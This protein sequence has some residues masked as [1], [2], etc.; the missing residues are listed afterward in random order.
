MI[1]RNAIG[2]L[3]CICKHVYAFTLAVRPLFVGYGVNRAVNM[4]N[5]PENLNPESRDRLIKFLSNQM[6]R[7][8]GYRREYREGKSIFNLDI[9]HVDLYILTQNTLIAPSKMSSWAPVTART[10]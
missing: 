8:L 3:Y 5:S 6:D 1:K 4:C 10:F 7:L 9:L 2:L